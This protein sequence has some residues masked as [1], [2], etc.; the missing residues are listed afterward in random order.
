[1]LVV[2]LLSNP[3][4]AKA[5]CYSSAEM[6]AEQFLRLH[7]ELMVIAYSCKRSSQNFDLI[8]VYTAFTQNN[9]GELQAADKTLLDHYKKQY[10]GDG[11]TQLDDLHTKLGNEAGQVIADQSLETFCDT[12]RDRPL[13]MFFIDRKQLR[14]EISNMMASAKSYCPLCKKP[15]SAVRTHKAK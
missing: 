8:S 2:L 3:V 7:S 11:L 13:K 5:E 1:V 10:G 14:D 9:L 12:N 6:R 15:G 4:F